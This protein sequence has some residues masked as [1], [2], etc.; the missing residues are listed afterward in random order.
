M[1]GN[2][3]GN[4]TNM[5]FNKSQDMVTPSLPTTNVTTASPPSMQVD[6]NMSEEPS[7]NVS[8]NI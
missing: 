6:E 1:S 2:F 5:Q 7:N 4:V 3:Y 8:S